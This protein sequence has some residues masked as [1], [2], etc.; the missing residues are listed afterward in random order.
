MILNNN[1]AEDLYKFETLSFQR[2]KARELHKIGGGER[3]VSNGSQSIY[4]IILNKTHA[5]VFILIQK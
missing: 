1:V 3:N 2:G 5:V 4:G